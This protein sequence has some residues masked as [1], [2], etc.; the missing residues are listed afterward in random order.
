MSEPSQDLT[1]IIQPG[2]NPQNEHRDP[3]PRALN[4]YRVEDVDRLLRNMDDRQAGLKRSLAQAYA[5][6]ERLAARIGSLQAQLDAAVEER[7]RLRHEAENPWETLGANA[8]KLI[9]DAKAQ[10]DDIRDHARADTEK[11]LQD[12]GTQATRMLEE[13]KTR[14]NGMIEEANRRISEADKALKERAAQADKDLNAREQ[15]FRERIA[16]ADR[17]RETRDRESQERADHATAAIREAKTMLK[18]LIDGLD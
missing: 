11:S 13:A 2:Q 5:N 14:A 8:Q 15:A 3:L 12:A 18:H 4:G 9:A 16:Q 17:E 10:A 7:D 6:Q 1:Q